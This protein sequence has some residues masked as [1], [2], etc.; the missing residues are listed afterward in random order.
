MQDN[1]STDYRPFKQAE[2]VGL[3][4]KLQIDME[5]MAQEFLPYKKPSMT[6]AKWWNLQLLARHFQDV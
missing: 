6:Q 1:K 5:M 2:T 4:Q 3:C